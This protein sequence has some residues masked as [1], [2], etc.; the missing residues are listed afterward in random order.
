MHYNTI[1]GTG[2]T[3]SQIGLGGHAFLADGR[4]K[5]MGESPKAKLPGE[6][7]PGFGG[8]KRKE[9]LKVAYEG[10]INFFDFTID[11]EKEA[12][13][14]NIKDLP[15][16]GNFYIQNRPEGLVYNNIPEDTEK[17][18]LLDYATLKSET[19]RGCKLVGR[20]PGQ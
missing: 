16:P 15:P 11:S 13:G 4:V 1:P 20:G 5:A 18:G 9:I 7:F 19:E 10:G 14:R 17:L 12:F 2:V 6:V 8:E 3:V